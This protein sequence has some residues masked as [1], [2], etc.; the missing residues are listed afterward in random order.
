[1]NKN[2][3][4]ELNLIKIP[5]D[6]DTKDPIANFLHENGVSGL[7]E[8][9]TEDGQFIVTYAEND[10]A[11]SL[12]SNLK[13]Y[14][15]EIA[16]FF[17]NSKIVEPIVSK[18]AKENW[19]TKW[20]DNFQT[21]H[22][23]KRLIVTPPWKPVS[24]TDEMV[25]IIEPAEAF[26][27]GTHETTQGCLVLLEI[28]FELLGKVNSV[29]DLGS[30]SGILAMAAKKLGAEIVLGI[31]NDPVAVDAAIQN[32]ELNQMNGDVDFK[33]TSIESIG[34]PYCLVLANLDLNTFRSYQGQIVE[35]A[36]EGLIISGLTEDQWLEVRD[37]LP[38]S[39]KL[40]KVIAQNDWV[41]G[42][43]IKTK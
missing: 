3:D 22:I 12:I 35:L 7:V 9:E 30:G 43:F 8:T 2:A 21:L 39:F 1:M 38:N 28:A 13:S 41:S 34:E 26:G 17:P 25:L 18:I 27:T 42:L 6:D 11:V 4:S 5:V 36:S 14:L 33:C 24:G 20:Q 10:L 16:S 40:E 15:I 29:L 19:A 37:A 31:D 23:G 32:R